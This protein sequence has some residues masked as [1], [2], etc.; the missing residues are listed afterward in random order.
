M[1]RSAELEQTWRELS[2][3]P[4]SVQRLA[5]TERSSQLKARVSLLDA[6]HATLSADVYWQQRVDLLD[7]LVTMEQAERLADISGYELVQ[8]RTPRAPYSLN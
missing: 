4:R 1:A 7:A 2:R 3:R 6:R 8:T 5:H